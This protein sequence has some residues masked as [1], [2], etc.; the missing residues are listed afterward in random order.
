[1]RPALVCATVSLSFLL[2]ACDGSR[3]PVGP[4]PT[5]RETGVAFRLDAAVEYSDSSVAVNGTRIIDYP[6]RDAAVFV[7][8]FHHFSLGGFD[9]M[10]YDE[11]ERV[12]ESWRIG[13][14]DRV[15]I[16]ERNDS[17]IWS[18]A[19]HGTLSVE[20]TPTDKL[21][22]IHVTPGDPLG[23]ENFVSYITSSSVHVTWVGGE[24]TEFTL[25]E[26]HD[27]LVSGENIE[28]TSTGSTETGA[29]A[30]S[31]RITPV[32]RLT[33]IENGDPLSL[34]VDEPIVVRSDT[35]LVLEFERPLD[36]ERAYILV[37]PYFGAPDAARG[38]FLQ[39]LEAAERVVI[40]GAILAELVGDVDGGRIPYW[41]VIEEFATE[42]AVF[43][44]VRADGEPFALPYG[45]ESETTVL[46]W[47]EP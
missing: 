34:D 9:H 28:I 6:P 8:H 37:M 31:F 11:D 22:E 46:M 42:D 4:D 35:T 41:I 16:V 15:S 32:A 26:Y 44:G 18:Y 39:P 20:G 24:T 21:T 7:E 13:V 17:T 47:L 5:P 40:P 27:D 45:Q 10:P 19:D 36:P 23:I 2:T 29:G 30:G 43:T 14:A 12:S 3:E 25:A 33:G 38:V 1:M